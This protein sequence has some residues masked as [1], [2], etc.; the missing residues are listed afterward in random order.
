[1]NRI[2]CIINILILGLLVFLLG[3]T[4]V[5]ANDYQNISFRDASGVVQSNPTGELWEKSLS[6]DR[7][8]FL[9]HE[10]EPN[11]G[12]YN[13]AYMEKWC[14]R[15]LEYRA[16]GATVLPTFDYNANW[17]WDKSERSYIHN[18][19]KWHIKPIDGG[20]F[21]C[22][23]FAPDG[24]EVQYG[25]PVDAYMPGL[26]IKNKLVEGSIMWPV[27]KEHVK[28]W[29][30][31][32]EKAV[33]RLRKEPYNVEYFQIWNE[34][35]PTSGFWFGDMDTFME[36]IYVPAAK[37]IRKYGGKVVYGGWCCGGPLKEYVALLDKHD[38]WKL[39]DVLDVHYF[40]ISSFEYL[41]SE[42]LKRGYDLPI[43][44]TE[45]GF[46]KQSS[47]I[48][49]TYPRFLSWALNNKWDDTNK[50]K[51]FYFAFWSPNDP[52]AYGYRCN[53]YSGEELTPHGASL[54]TMGELFAGGNIRIRKGIKTEPPL[55]FEINEKLSSVEAFEC[56]DHIIIAVHL[57]PNNTAN[58]FTD[59]NQTKDSMHLGHDN[60]MIKIC[61]DN[62]DLLCV[63]SVQRVDPAGYCSDYTPSVKTVR[64]GIELM[65][66]IRHDAISPVVEWSKEG[67]EVT[68]F[69]ID[70]QLKALTVKSKKGVNK[71][72][73]DANL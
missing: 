69:F 61:V 50:Y 28:N 12:K 49:N 30:A 71:E 14:K 55:K 10:Y 57:V 33:S 22:R 20:K 25:G 44:Q 64:G 72:V 27:A 67:D 34:A 16:K 6:W 40:P 73:K 45:L 11:E 56:G 42:S 21:E 46:T 17:S 58:I 1:M 63:D 65:V 47:F 15:F 66:P 53:L 13:D 54:K 31:F 70:V 48:S 59:W 60:P 5:Q 51:L 23:I 7:L 24:N 32:I 68:T 36:R 43:W 18:G 4:N 9:W 19:F 39:T 41:R 3:T 38:A 52:N 62:V 35:W 2:V 29:E 8:D 37:I 26:S